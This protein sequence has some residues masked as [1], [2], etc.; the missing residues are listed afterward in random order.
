MRIQ[1]LK[2]KYPNLYIE[3]MWHAV[4]QGHRSPQEIER[5][6]HLSSLFSW[7][8]T[9]QGSKYWNEVRQGRS[10]AEKEAGLMV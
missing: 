1:K 6:G 9:R 7:S 10:L 2:N 8:H 5:I 4:R 3:A